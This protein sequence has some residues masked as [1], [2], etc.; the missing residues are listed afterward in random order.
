MRT[1]IC[2]P[3]TG[4]RRSARPRSEGRS[5]SRRPSASTTTTTTRSRRPAGPAPRTRARRRGVATPCSAP[6]PCPSARRGASGVSTVSSG[7]CSSREHVGG[8]VGRAVVDHDDR[9]VGGL[10]CQQAL[11]A[12]ADRHLLVQSRHEEHPEEVIGRGA[13]SGS[14]AVRAPPTRRANSTLVHASTAD[15]EHEGDAEEQLAPGRAGPSN[16]IASAITGRPSGR[17]PRSDRAERRVR[18]AG[19]AEQPDRVA[20]RLEHHLAREARPE[21]D[22]C[23]R[24]SRRDTR[25]PR[26]SVRPRGRRRTGLAAGSTAVCAGSASTVVD[27]G[28][29]ASRA[30]CRRASASPRRPPRRARCSRGR[31]APARRAPA[32]PPGFH[33]S[34]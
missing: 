31:R 17:S 6:R 34:R 7:S 29:D 22:G 25:A 5:G 10:D 12:V 13:S 9:L 27:R 26:R 14:G 33:P 20:G 18:S 3:P 24:G 11:D 21:P 30:R 16:G 8:A 1:R 28:D 4:G 15:D 32:P 19:V 2:S 23:R